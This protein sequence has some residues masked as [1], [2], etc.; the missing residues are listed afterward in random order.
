MQE[1]GAHRSGG[2]HRCE[3][4]IGAGSRTSMG[5]G[6]IAAAGG[7]PSLLRAGLPCALLG[8]RS[9]GKKRKER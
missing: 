6:I 4:V 3:E 7:L 2:G 8:S 1:V 9:G 5:S